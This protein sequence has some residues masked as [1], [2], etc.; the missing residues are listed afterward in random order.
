PIDAVRK[1]NQDLAAKAR[2]SS[3]LAGT[4]SQDKRDKYLKAG[5][6][7]AASTDFQKLLAA[8]K[9]EREQSTGEAAPPVTEDRPKI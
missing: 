1:A 6:T 2:V 4:D 8:R 5:E 7:S 9:A 3:R